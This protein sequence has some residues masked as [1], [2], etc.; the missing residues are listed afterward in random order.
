MDMDIFPWLIALLLVALA[1]WQTLGAKMAARRA[2][3]EACRD[4]EVRF[5]DE[6]AL[7]RL[8]IGRSQGRDGRRRYRVKRV[9]GFEFYWGG[10]RRYAGEIVMHGQR[11]AAVHMD[12][13]PL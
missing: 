1:W 2:A 9:Y 3:R 10:E 11:V 4:A 7:K 12:P 5:I 6:L 8:T 13:Y